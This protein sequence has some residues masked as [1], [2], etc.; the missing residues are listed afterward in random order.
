[1]PLIDGKAVPVWKAY[2][3]AHK[4]SATLFRTRLKSVREFFERCGPDATVLTDGSGA[5]NQN[6]LD[7]LEVAGFLAEMH[8]V[9]KAE[10]AYL[11]AIDESPLDATIW[12]DLVNMYMHFELWKPA[13]KTVSRA[14]SIFTH[15]PD[16][17]ALDSTVR[18]G[19]RQLFE[20]AAKAISK[21]DH[22]NA[23]MSVIEYLAVYPE[24]EKAKSLKAQLLKPV[25]P[26][27]ERQADSKAGMVR[28][29]EYFIDQE[30]PDR[31]IG[32]LEGL[33]DRGLSMQ[34]DH[35]ETIGDLRLRQKD[36]RSAAWHY[37]KSLAHLPGSR[38]LER[39]LERCNALKIENGSIQQETLR[40]ESE[41]SK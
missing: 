41:L 13:L 39:K 6:K 1:L 36:I 25:K 31:A 18:A 32:I 9:Q 40:H 30:Q 5:L 22:E 17:A 28:Q 3:G 37:T 11:R 38:R 20:K 34:S 35:L 14:R 24:N 8:E 12:L 7:D 19:I 29:A 2:F 27:A 4:T 33:V 26:D 16:V 15:N 10:A 23:R 21:A